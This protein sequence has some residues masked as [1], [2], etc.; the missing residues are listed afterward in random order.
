[1]SAG[2]H[3]GVFCFHSLAFNNGFHRQATSRLTRSAQSSEQVSPSRRFVLAAICSGPGKPI[4]RRIEEV[5]PLGTESARPKFLLSDYRLSDSAINLITGT[6][7]RFQ[8]CT[9]RTFESNQVRLGVSATNHDHLPMMM[10]RLLAPTT[11]SIMTRTSETPAPATAS[12]A[13]P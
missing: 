4:H 11:T 10:G 13:E 5:K 6:F 9:Q 7:H 12:A 2:L 8:S 1:M 3:H